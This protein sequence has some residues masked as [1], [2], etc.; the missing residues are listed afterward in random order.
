M[1]NV[2]LNR[3]PLVFI[4]PRKK[5]R[6]QRW[7]LLKLTSTEDKINLLSASNPEFDCWRWV[8]YWYPVR[9]VIS[10]KKEVYRKTLR[11]FSSIAMPFKVKK[12]RKPKKSRYQK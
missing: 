12:Y 11:D 8:S 3:A 6:K 10:F 2:R 5:K 7:F 1:T 4:K 9:Q